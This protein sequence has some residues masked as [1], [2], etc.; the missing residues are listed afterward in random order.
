MD[1][2]VIRR[3]LTAETRVQ[4]WA[5]VCGICGEEC[6]TEAGISLSNLITHS[7]VSSHQCSVH[8]HSFNTDAMSS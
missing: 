7:S 5:S 2:A 3:P 6:A 4:S 1:Q 8:I